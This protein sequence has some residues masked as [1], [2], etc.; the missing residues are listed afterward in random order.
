MATYL[1]RRALEANEQ[2]LVAS[3]E[4]SRHW[5]N[6]GLVYLR[7]EHYN[8]ALYCFER[9]VTIDTGFLDAL[10]YMAQIR[11]QLGDVEEANDSLR[12]ILQLNPAPEHEK[13][14]RNWLQGQKQ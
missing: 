12:R 3:P 4:N 6:T 2:A 5:F 14:I 11:F 1:R 7:L 8:S 10:D 13:R 9:A